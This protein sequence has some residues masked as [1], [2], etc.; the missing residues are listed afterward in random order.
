MW[1]NLDSFYVFFLFHHGVD[2]TLFV[3]RFIVYY[4]CNHGDELTETFW[5]RIPD[6]RNQ[7]CD[8]KNL[9]LSMYILPKRNKY[10]LN[11]HNNY[12]PSPCLNVPHERKISNGWNNDLLLMSKT[13]NALFYFHS[14]LTRKSLHTQNKQIKKVRPDMIQTPV[15]SE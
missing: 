8:Y 12:H 13:W 4:T 14:Q 10:I 9:C 5:V 11:V 3:I 1:Y 2:G 6:E 15:E 7:L